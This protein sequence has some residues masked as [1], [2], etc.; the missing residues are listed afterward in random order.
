MLD[1]EQPPKEPL[2]LAWPVMGLVTCV[3]L[4]V[5]AM[6][7]AVLSLFSTSWGDES[8]SAFTRFTFLAPDVPPENSTT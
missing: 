1:Q 7:N 5:L 8:I 3:V 2:S 4:F 6:I